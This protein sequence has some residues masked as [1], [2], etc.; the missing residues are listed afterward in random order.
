MLDAAR[1]QSPGEKGWA[2]GRVDDDACI[3]T[4]RSRARGVEPPAPVASLHGAQARSPKPL[5]TSLDSPRSEQLLETATI[6]DPTGTQRLA[7]PIAVRYFAA[8]PG[9]ADSGTATRYIGPL[10]EYRR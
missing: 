1:S 6:D 9:G 7:K 3:E 4:F 10:C 2:A 8:S 5:R